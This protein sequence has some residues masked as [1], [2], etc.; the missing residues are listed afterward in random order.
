MTSDRRALYDDLAGIQEIAA[1]LGV[2][3]FRVK[4][5]IERRQ[6][7]LT[8]APVKELAAGNVYSLAEWQAWYRLWKI[9]RAYQPAEAA[10]P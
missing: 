5:W 10:R 4:R 3:V 2:P 1:A 6:S 8:P 9:T 7:T